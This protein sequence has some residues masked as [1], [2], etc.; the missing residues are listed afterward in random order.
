[1]VEATLE[2][3]DTEAKK[4][5]PSRPKSAES[6]KQKTKRTSL[7]SLPEEATEIVGSRVPEVEKELDEESADAAE[8]NVEAQR[9]VVPG[10]L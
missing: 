10:E 3:G 8:G 4:A 5:V 6:G 7:F 1:M 9:Q 2:E